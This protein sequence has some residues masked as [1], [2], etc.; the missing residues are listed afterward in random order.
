MICEDE[1]HK[2]REWGGIAALNRRERGNTYGAERSRQRRWRWKNRKVKQGERDENFGG[3]TRECGHER[4]RENNTKS[5]N[6]TTRLET[7]LL[8]S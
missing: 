8:G 1:N 4:K 6:L 3:R 5:A 7:W 2:T